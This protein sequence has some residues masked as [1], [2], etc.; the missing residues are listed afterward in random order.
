MPKLRFRM[1]KEDSLKLRITVNFKADHVNAYDS[2]CGDQATASA[3]FMA[4]HV[5][6]SLSS[7]G[8]LNDDI[9]TLTY[10]SNTLS[11][12]PHYDTYHDDDY[13]LNYVVQEMKYDE[14][15]V[16]HDDYMLNLR[17][18]VM[19]SLMM[20]IWSPFKMKLITMFLLLYKI[21]K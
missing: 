17:V 10:D 21:K 15:S 19:S 12:V 5:K 16:S 4:Y 9:V 1:I 13:V 20:S 18:T 14:H 2:N 3:I 11:E 7:I 6:D 8:S